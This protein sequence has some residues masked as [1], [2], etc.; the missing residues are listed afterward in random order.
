MTLQGNFLSF[1]ELRR[2]LAWAL[3]DAGAVLTSESDHPRVITRDGPHGPE[4]GFHLRHHEKSPKAPLSPIYLNLRTP[5]NPNPGPLTSEIVDMAAA[6]MNRLVSL[7]EL[8][9]HLVAGV[10]NAGGPFAEAFARELGV[11]HALLRMI[12]EKIPSSRRP[13]ITLA[14]QVNRRGMTA[15]V[16]DDV[17]SDA[18][19]KFETIRLLEEAGLTVRDIIVLVDRGQGGREKLAKLGYTLHSVFKLPEL[20]NLCVKSSRISPAL[21]GDIE[22]YLA[23]H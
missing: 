4:R 20:L 12:K 5:D 11:P 2:R 1:D 9:Y 10:P 18:E 17:V 6:C 14:S 19:S 13:V 16:I 22:A 8:D 3:I 23:T 7:R 21:V 15:I